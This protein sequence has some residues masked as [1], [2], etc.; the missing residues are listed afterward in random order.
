MKIGVE[1]KIDVTKIEKM[2]LFKGDKGTYLTMTTFI[3][4]EVV[5]N[6]GNNGFIAHKKDKDEER[7]PILGNV[8][9]F[10]NPSENQQVP[11]QAPA[12]EKDPTIYDDDI[13]F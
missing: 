3:D 1:V 13:P 2:R 8:K 7:T 9:V 11:E 12:A 4:T 10:W 5:D 6:Y